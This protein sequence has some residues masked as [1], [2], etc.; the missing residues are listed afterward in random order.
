MI[1]CLAVY[2][3]VMFVQI[4]ILIL[5]CKKQLSIFQTKSLF[6]KDQ[7]TICLKMQ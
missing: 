4:D 5:G 6:K 3:M 7:V 1:Y 2:D